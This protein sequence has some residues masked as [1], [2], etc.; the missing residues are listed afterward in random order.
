MIF[1]ITFK[2]GFKPAGGIRTCQDAIL[3]QELM[4]K[5]LDKRWLF[6]N[7]FRIGASGLLGDI[8]DYVTEYVTKN[9]D[10]I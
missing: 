7:L 5:E 8:E 10:K 6:P 2:V 1:H 3:W 9:C 4:A